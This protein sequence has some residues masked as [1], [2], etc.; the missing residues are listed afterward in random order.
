ARGQRLDARAFL[1]LRPDIPAVLRV[2]VT[3]PDDPTP[4][5]LLSTRRPE[6]LAAAIAASA[7]NDS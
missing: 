4:Y 1:V 3:D 6:E 7:R 5:W 2:A